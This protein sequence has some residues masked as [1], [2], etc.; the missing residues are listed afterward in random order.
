MD[1]NYNVRVYV[2]K[3]VLIRVLNTWLDA[4]GILRVWREFVPT[5]CLSSSN[6]IDDYVSTV[7]HF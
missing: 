3:S 6:L 5:F 1:Y 7:H 4:G 2:C